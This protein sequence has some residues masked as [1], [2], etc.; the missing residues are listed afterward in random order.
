MI[1]E[2]EMNCEF[3][4]AFQKTIP[5]LA[6]FAFLGMAYGLY[7]NQLGFNFLYPTLMAM[8]IFGGSVEFV[9][10]NALLKAFNPWGVL[11]LTAIINSRH[12]FYGISMLERYKNTGWRKVY[13][14]FGMVDE[15]FSINYATKLPEDVDRKKFY[16]YVTLLDHF[17]WV[18]GTMAGAL[19]GSLITFQIKGIDF[20][21]V[22]LFIV[23]FMDQYV[24]EEKHFNSLTG[25][26]LALA[27][28]FIFGLEYF[29]PISML[30]MVGV[31]YIRYRKEQ[32][33]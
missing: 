2:N 7:M 6:G 33:L 31:L 4:L 12:L 15:S 22:A 27:S 14:L 25:I 11:L 24:N 13:L 28:L 1:R 10:G 5:I 32:Q 19:L 23:L 29:L 18:M 3:K 30:L 17:Y 21:M 20:V 8:T 16:F 26:V 9:V